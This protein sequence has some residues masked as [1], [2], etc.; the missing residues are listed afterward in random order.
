MIWYVVGVWIYENT[1]DGCIDLIPIFMCVYVFEL[2][3]PKSYF[4]VRWRQHRFGCGRTIASRPLSLRSGRTRLSCRYRP[5]RGRNTV[6][7][8]EAGAERTYLSL[9]EIWKIYV[10]RQRRTSRRARMS[11]SFLSKR[12]IV[13]FPWHLGCGCA[14]LLC[15]GCICM[16]RISLGGGTPF[17]PRAAVILET[18]HGKEAWGPT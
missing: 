3:F 8:E 15:F 11:P 14:A 7:L 13:L 4:T 1:C 18:R 17:G 5:T 6:T 16:S 9:Q 10:I 2:G 12:P